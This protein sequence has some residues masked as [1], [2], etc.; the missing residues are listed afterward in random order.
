MDTKELGGLHLFL[1]PVVNEHLF[2]LLDVEKEIVAQPY[3]I[4]VAVTLLPTTVVS[5]ANLMMWFER[6]LEV[7]C[8]ESKE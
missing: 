2:G 3:I 4:M 6:E 5:S 8:Q 7:V 1:F